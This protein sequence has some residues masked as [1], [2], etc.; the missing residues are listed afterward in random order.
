V[1]GQVIFEVPG[2]DAAAPGRAPL[3]EV[4]KV[5]LIDPSVNR[6]GF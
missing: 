4:K 1:S 5:L 3:A 6:T 2:A